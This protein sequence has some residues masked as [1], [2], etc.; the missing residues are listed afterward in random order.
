MAR[1]AEAQA[2]ATELLDY[3]ITVDEK[4]SDT[5][6]AFKELPRQIGQKRDPTVSTTASV[7]CPA[8]LT[9]GF[10]LI[11]IT[12][13]RSAGR[14]RGPRPRPPRGPQPRPTPRP[15]VRPAPAQHSLF[16]VIRSQQPAH[17]SPPLW[18]RRAGSNSR[19]E[20][21]IAIQDRVFLHGP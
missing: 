4:G 15:T 19:G 3:E 12:A 8:V 21:T 13:V 7:P 2:L 11:T 18:V 14:H 1:T 6:G 17:P 10:S 5:Y 20:P 9:A 16:R